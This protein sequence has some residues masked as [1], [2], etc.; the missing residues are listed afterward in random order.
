MVVDVKVDEIIIAVLGGLRIELWLEV[1]S[2][3]GQLGTWR[4]LAD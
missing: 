4:Y 2:L 3:E 1:G